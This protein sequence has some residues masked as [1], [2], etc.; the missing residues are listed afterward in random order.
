MQAPH[1][2]SS[3]PSFEPVRPIDV[4]HGGEQVRAGLELDRVGDPVHVQRRRDLHAS[5]LAA[6]V[7]AP[8]RS[9]AARSRRPSRAGSRPS[10]GRRRSGVAAAATAAPAASIAAA[11]PSLP[12]ERRLGLRH[13]PDRRRERGH[14]DPRVG[15]GAVGEGDDGGRADDGDLHLPPVLEPQVG[16]ARAVGRERERRSRRAA[17][18]PR[19]VVAPGPV[20]RSSIATAAS[21]A[22]DCS[23]T[24]APKQTSGPPVSIAGEAFITLPPIVPCARVACEPTIA[25]ASASAVKRGADVVARGDLR[26]AR[27]RAEPE[28][29]V[30]ERLD[31][32]E[33]GDAVDRDDAVRAA[34]TCRSGRRRRGRCRRRPGR[35]PAASAARASSTVVGR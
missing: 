22:G 6:R 21:P 2:E 14:R 28:A 35:A 18:R 27:E 26:V 33:L 9:R 31:A 3:Q 34:S 10:R 30:V 19:A 15:H 25:Q 1:S 12:I 7:R 4:A 23:V 5:S 16:A 32:V 24:V 13:A 20:Q 8:S 17:R 11:P 29:S